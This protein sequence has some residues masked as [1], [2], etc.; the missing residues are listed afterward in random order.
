MKPTK[1]RIF[2]PQS[3]RPKMIFETKEKAERFLEYNVVGEAEFLKKGK[4]PTRAYYCAFCNGWH[5]TSSKK[6]NMSEEEDL[7]LQ[8]EKISGV[9]SNSKK[10]PTS[11]EEEHNVGDDIVIKVR[12]CF[13]RDVVPMLS[14]KKWKTMKD[15]E[16]RILLNQMKDY[17]R[18]LDGIKSRKYSV[19]GLLKQISTYEE[20]VFSGLYNNQLKSL[21]NKILESGFLFGMGQT[22]L[23]KA[24]LK[25]VDDTLRY[26]V[27]EVGID[28]RNRSE[29]GRVKQEIIHLKERFVYD[30]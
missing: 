26:L 4:V 22:D 21:S 7:K 6:R 9:A 29:V 16:L 28:E 15:S 24:E 30:N 25:E 2:C 5:L 14:N 23:A 1:N 3:G 18:R 20:L 13:L 17:R 19:N 12:K 8:L 11:S 27:E 10:L